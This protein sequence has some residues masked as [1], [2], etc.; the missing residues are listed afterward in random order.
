MSY[1][2]TSR[3]FKATFPGSENIKEI[4]SE[5]G[6][7]LF[8]L[9]L[10]DGK[11]NG[12]YLEIGTGHSKDKSNTFLLES[13]FGW[14]GASIDIESKYVKEHNQNRKTKAEVGDGTTVN[15]V[16]ILHRAGITDTD[17]DYASVNCEPTSDTFLSL[18][19]MPFNTHRFGIITY[20]HNSYVGESQY[21][22]LSRKFLK[23][24]GYLLLVPNISIW[25][26]PNSVYE[27][28]WVH[29]ELISQDIRNQYKSDIDLYNNWKDILFNKRITLYWD[30]RI[31]T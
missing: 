11:K 29:P 21:R 14:K 28:W 6:Q 4:Y 1:L 15:Y 10:L 26:Y 17:I 20:E 31:P 16:D 12:T 13:Q 24:K 23:N 7:D 19:N 5:A 2:V 18:I 30:T 22:T 9:S 8:V 27:D 25:G 3:I